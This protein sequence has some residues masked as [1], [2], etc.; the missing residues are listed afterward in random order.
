M[1][2]FICVACRYKHSKRM[3]V[4]KEGFTYTVCPKCG[5]GGFIKEGD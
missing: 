2:K 1:I 4:K 5:C 3:R